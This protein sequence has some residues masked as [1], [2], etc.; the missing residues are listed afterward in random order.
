MSLSRRSFLLA[1]T[2]AVGAAAL[3]SFVTTGT[4]RAATSPKHLITVFASGGWDTTYALDPK[5]GVKG[6]DGPTDGTVKTFGDLPIYTAASRPAVAGFFEKYA[7]ITAVV[8]GIQVRAINHPDCSKRILTGT[9]SEA[10]PDMG[11]I[12][13]YEL[14]RDRPAPYLVL[15]PSAVSGP[16]ASIAARAGSVNQIRSLLDPMASLPKAPPFDADRY[17]PDADEAGLLKAFVKAR[18]ERAKALRGK[19]GYNADRYDDFLSSL[20]RR[21]VLRGFADGF[22]DDFTFTLD[23]REQIKLGLDAI[24]RGVCWSL[25][26]E[27][28]YGSWDT[29]TDNSIQD[30]QHQD[31]YDALTQ[32]ADSLAARPGSAAGKTMLDE[33]VVAVVS[34]MGRT[35]KLNDQ[36]GK[37]HWPVTSALLFGAGVKGGRVLGGSD[38]ELQARNVDLHTGEALDGSGQQ[39]QYGNLASG[40]LGLVGVDA[41]AYLPNL[42]AFD[43]IVA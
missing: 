19:K 31:M 32:L 22:G 42:G 35:P 23:I 6:I 15:G 26:L 11:S 8:N 20:E 41:A 10:N 18:A 14:G 24:E 3:P 29:H 33:T 12:T 2:A 37:D 13:A 21:D 34:E 16:L 38:G 25:H 40:V 39:L 4:A 9:Q 36:N 7:P 5:A 1:G 30:M 43:A 27:Q 17:A 28:A